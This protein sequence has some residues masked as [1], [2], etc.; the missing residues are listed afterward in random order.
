MA[1][2]AG[3]FAASGRQVS[4]VDQQTDS[5]IGSHKVVYI[6]GKPAD[7]ATRAYV[8]SIRQRI[9]VFYYDQFRHFSDPAAMLEDEMYT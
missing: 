1:A 3:V 6:D 8:D 7:A 5:L 4:L 9:S 2:V